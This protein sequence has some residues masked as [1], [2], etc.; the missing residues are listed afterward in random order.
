MGNLDVLGATRETYAS[1]QAF[2]HHTTTKHKEQ[3]SFPDQ[4]KGMWFCVQNV[5]FLRFWKYCTI[6]F[7]T[8][9]PRHSKTS[10]GSL[11][12]G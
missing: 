12:S 7:P 11:L 2:D 6:C 9:R 3:S 4:I 8:E 1:H 10:P 5:F